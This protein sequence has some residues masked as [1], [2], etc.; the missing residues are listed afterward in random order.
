MEQAQ[1]AKKQGVT[2]VRLPVLSFTEYC[3]VFEHEDDFSSRQAHRAHQKRNFYFKR[4]L[5]NQGID[6]TMVTCRSHEL[7]TWAREHEHALNTDRERTHAL[8]H[9]VS[10]P[11]LP[12]A[13]CVHKRPLT[14]AM[15]DSGLELYATI[16]TYGESPERPE[17]LSTAVHTQEGQVVESLEILAVDHSPQEAF[18]LCSDFMAKHGVV[19]AFHDSTVRRPEFCPDCG[20][21]LVNVA[22]LSEYDRLDKQ[23]DNIEDIQ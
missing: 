7:A 20:E 8:A 23:F 4:F 15:A 19:N 9:F 10:R 21:L 18:G 13:A 17:V 14:A 16:T 22:G 3:R 1:A 11:D 6:V 2:S 5:E 12:P